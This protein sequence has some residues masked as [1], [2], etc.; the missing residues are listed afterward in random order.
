M[1]IPIVAIVGK[2]KTGKTT[3]VEGLIKALKSKGYRV[4][5]AKHTSHEVVLDKPG[6]DSWRHIQA[7]SEATVISSLY[8]LALIKPIAKTPSL[9]EIARLFGNDYDIIIVEGFKSVWRFHQHGI[10]NTVA[11]MGSNITLGQIGLLCEYALNG[12]V[13]MF[14]NDVAGYSGCVSACNNLKN[15]VDAVPIF[16]TDVDEEGKGLDPSDLSKK[17]IYDYLKGCF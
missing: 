16:I 5:T 1:M 17:V 14:D 6:K 11:V 15:R 8:Q 9:D 7:G 10:S 3:L 2:S 13:I 4:A 12:V